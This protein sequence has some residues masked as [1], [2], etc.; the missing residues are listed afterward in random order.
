MILRCPHLAFLPGKRPCSEVAF[1]SNFPRSGRLGVHSYANAINGEAAAFANSSAIRAGILDRRTWE[2]QLWVRSLFS[3]V[4]FYQI[5][6]MLQRFHF[7]CFRGSFLLLLSMQTLRQVR[8][9]QRN[10]LKGRTNGEDLHSC[11]LTE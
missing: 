4:R 11:H 9:H 1:Y 6:F 3:A 10:P 5:N 8:S 2:K 7:E